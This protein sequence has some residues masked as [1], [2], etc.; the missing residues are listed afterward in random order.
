MSTKTLRKRI[1]LV[2]VSALTAG[3]FSVAS[4][5]VANATLSSTA[6]QKANIFMVPATSADANFVGQCA[7]ATSARAADLTTINSTGSVLAVGAKVNFDTTTSGAGNLVVTGPATLAM[8]VTTTATI[9]QD[10]K[11]VGFADN[12]NNVATLTVTG[13]G[14]IV[15]TAN[16]S[17]TI[18]A[19]TAVKTFSIS[20][21]TSCSA[22][23][24]PSITESILTIRNAADEGASAT[25]TDDSLAI[26]DKDYASVVNIAVELKNA[27]KADLT[28]DGILTA[29]ATG[30]ALVG[31]DAAAALG[32]TAFA[33]T[34]AAVGDTFDFTVAQNTTT[35]P[36]A[37]LTTTV[38]VKFN[39]VT[40]GTK[41]ITI[42]GLPT[43][44]VVDQADVT[45]GVQGG[46]GAFQYSVQDAAGNTLA[47]NSGV[48]P[49]GSTMTGAIAGVTYAG[50]VS[51]VIGT[52]NSTTAAKGTGT[53]D[54]LA[55][56]AGKS[57]GSQA[58]Q[59]GAQVGTL[60]VKSNTFT[61]TCGSAGVGSFTA[62]MDKAVYSPGEIATLTITAKDLNGG[63]VADTA[64]IGAAY[65][66][67]SIAGMTIIGAAIS[68]ADVF[69]SG[70]KTYKFRVDQNEG[71]FVGQAQ[72]T[73]TT[74]AATAETTVKTVQYSIKQSGTTVT[75]AEVLKSIVALIASI[76]KQIQA[77]QK[78]ILK[79]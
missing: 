22:A 55:F 64:V 44:L 58:V 27:Y 79:R 57:S 59:L 10:S 54:C 52:S 68:S 67:I 36:G 13:T 18:G 66:K 21:V 9:S 63:V 45:V 3:V 28:A 61:A 74:G 29:E 24:V 33:S 26:T 25:R 31:V 75:N 51:N 76:N 14:D 77:L 32:A 37:P 56:S 16:N 19:G 71:S 20:A 4:A 2:A 7:I 35:A 49:A 72:V 48:V 62:A 5:P 15:V 11:T 17:A 23:D 65:D 78:L 1:A 69:T 40:I 39:G 34:N 73:T 41:T 46:T 43:K 53:F 70:T 30:N 60:V 50:I 47:A 6:I 12:I 8:V 38:T 42:F